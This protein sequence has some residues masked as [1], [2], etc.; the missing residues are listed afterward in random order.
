MTCL[1]IK[2]K[3]DILTKPNSM[4]TKICCLLDII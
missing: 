3:D 2:Y 4:Y 1:L